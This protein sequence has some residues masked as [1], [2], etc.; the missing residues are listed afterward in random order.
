MA[1]LSCAND[2]VLHVVVSEEGPHAEEGAGDGCDLELQLGLVPFLED[3][4]LE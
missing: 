1:I 2:W 3:P 4:L